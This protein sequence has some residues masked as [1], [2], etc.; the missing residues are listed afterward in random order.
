MGD[1]RQRQKRELQQGAG[2]RAAHRAPAALR[3]A[4]AGR[5]TSA[6]APL[7]R[8]AIGKA[9]SAVTYPSRAATKPPPSPI[10]R[11]TASAMSSSF[12]PTTQIL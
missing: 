4:T 7:I 11:L 9:S 6:D 5:T 12:A 8:P 2:K 3:V 1:D 10:K